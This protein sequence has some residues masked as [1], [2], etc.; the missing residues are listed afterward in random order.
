MNVMTGHINFESVA[1]LALSQSRSLVPQWLPN[2]RLHGHEFRVG[3]LDGAPGESLSV[4]LNS[5]LWSDFATGD[6]GG[7]LVSLYAGCHQLS[8]VEAARE[9]SNILGGV[10][11]SRISITNARSGSPAQEWTAIVPV[12]ADAP[13]PPAA[14]PKHGQPTHIARYLTRDGALIGLVL[15]CEPEGKRKEIPSLTFCEDTSGQR[16]WRW[17]SLPKPRSLYGA[18]RLNQPGQVL[19]VEG[20]PKCDAARRMLVN[21]PVTVIAWPGGSKAAGLADWSLLTGRDVVIWPDADGPGYDAA[22]Q[23]TIQLRH[24]GARA[25]TAELPSNLPKGWDL[26]DAE[27]EGW[28]GDRVMA[29]IAPRAQDPGIPVI[30]A[31]A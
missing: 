18:E 24:H 9:L 29:Q 10:S 2:G 11:E 20:E 31:R 17:Q 1:A 6:K 4:N 27:R 12:P 25:R 23:I 14:H 16:Q 28:T 3:G 21:H 5:G 22:A 7:D 26:A 13:A 15:R 30:R 19:V 8:Q